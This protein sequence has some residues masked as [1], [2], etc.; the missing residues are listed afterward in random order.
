MSLTVDRFEN[1]FAVCERADG[2]MTRIPIGQLPAEVQEGSILRE[3]NGKY[4][5]CLG[6][7]AARR[8][9]LE[10]KLAAILKKK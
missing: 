5:L 9:R 7:E 6:Q 2:G 4:T 3:E 1:G 10:D 8:G